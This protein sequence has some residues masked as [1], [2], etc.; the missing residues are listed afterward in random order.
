VAGACRAGVL[1]LSAPETDGSARTVPIPR[2]LAMI[3]DRL[4][5]EDVQASRQLVLGLVPLILSN[6][7][8]KV[9]TQDELSAPLSQELLTSLDSH[10]RMTVSEFDV[11]I[12]LDNAPGLANGG[13]AGEPRAGEDHAQRGDRAESGRTSRPRTCRSSRTCSRR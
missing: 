6:E 8:A 9:G 12:T 3:E 11:L 10:E 13:R 7:H 1:R 5:F 2:E 4:R